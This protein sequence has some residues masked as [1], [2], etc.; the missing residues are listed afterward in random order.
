M[1]LDQWETAT[2]HATK[3]D[4]ENAVEEQLV[5]YFYLREL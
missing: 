3:N 4:P 5:N 2:Q 1:W